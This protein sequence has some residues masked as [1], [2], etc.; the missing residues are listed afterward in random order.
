MY[1]IQGNQIRIQD[2]TGP[3]HSEVVANGERAILKGD[4]I[5]SMNRSG[6]LNLHVWTYHPR[7]NQPALVYP[8]LSVDYP[9]LKQRFLLTEPVPKRKHKKEVAPSV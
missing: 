3:V 4:I 2:S 9:S 8:A 5:L 7:D 6:G 1:I